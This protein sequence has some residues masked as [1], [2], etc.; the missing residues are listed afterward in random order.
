MAV[1]YVAPR[2]LGQ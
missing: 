2:W 1:G